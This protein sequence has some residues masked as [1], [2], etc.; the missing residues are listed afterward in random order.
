MISSDHTKAKHVAFIVKDLKPL[1]AGTCRETGHHLDF[2]KTTHVSIAHG[3]VAALEEM[4]VCLGV[5]KATNERPNCLHGGLDGLNHRR[6]TL[7]RSQGVDVV[8]RDRVRQRD[9]VRKR[10]TACQGL[11]LL[12]VVAT[13]AEGGGGAMEVQG[14]RHLDSCVVS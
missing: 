12:F 8:R 6:T 3:Y 9:V 2:A 5:V 11:G 4:L 7:V 13:A 14:G 10:E 1:R